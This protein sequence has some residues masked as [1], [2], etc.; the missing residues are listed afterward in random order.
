MHDGAWFAVAMCDAWRATGDPFYKEVLVKWQLPFYLRMLNDSAQLFSDEK[1]DVRPEG[2]DTWKG[3]KEWLL[4]GR[5]NGFVPYWWDDGESVS[6]EMLGKKSAQ[7]FYPCTNELAGQPNPD[8]RLK[9]WSHGSSNHLAQDLG[10]MLLQA[11]LVLHD[12]KDATEQALAKEVALA[13]KNLQECRARH[14]SANIPAC[15]AAYALTNSDAAA[16][17]KLDE[18]RYSVEYVEP[19]LTFSERLAMSFATEAIPF[20]DKAFGL[21]KWSVVLAQ[22][23]E[24]AL[25]PLAFVSRWNDPRGVY[26]YCFCDVH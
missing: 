26:A 20:A 4:Q 1:V 8:F 21:P 25:E 6:L 18:G 13:A 9:G 11:W 7:P 17:A 10:V 15:V 12:S 3:A 19:D 5:E 24:S 2:K 16:L 22:A 23:V 14:G